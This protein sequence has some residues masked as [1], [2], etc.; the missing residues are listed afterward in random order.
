M[1]H[2]NPVPLTAISSGLTESPSPSLNPAA[3][4]IK[5]VDQPS[6]VGKAPHMMINK[7][8]HKGKPGAKAR[9]ARDAKITIAEHIIA[10]RIAMA[11]VGELS[12]MVKSLL[13][14][15]NL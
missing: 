4:H 14:R 3:T 13:M 2:R 7:G 12:K 11:N 5:P 15:L 8:K 6:D 10:K 1:T 9:I